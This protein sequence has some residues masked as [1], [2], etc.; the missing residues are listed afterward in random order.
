MPLRSFRDYG[1]GN[2]PLREVPH[3]CP[4]GRL[5]IKL[6]MVNPH[7]SIKDRTAFYL[8]RDIQ[9][10]GQLRSDVTI[11]ESSSGNL[12]MALG[13]LARDA[14]VRFVCLMDHS[15]PPE[16][17]AELSDAGIEV[18]I[19]GRGRYPDCRT[20]RMRRAEE[21]GNHEGWLW[22]NQYANSANVLA[23]YE[24]TGREI[25]EQTDGAVAFV[26][27][28]AGTAGTICGIGQC[29]K[30]RNKHVTVVAVE[31]LGS[32]LFGG[33]EG[34]YL[35][36][37]AGLRGPSRILHRHGHVIDYFCKM[38][39][40]TA[41]AECLRLQQAE[42]LDVGITTGSV[43]RVGSM[44]ASEHPEDI[45]VVVSPDGGE[46]YAHLIHDVSP[47]PEVRETVRLTPFHWEGLDG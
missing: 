14:G 47:S 46:K 32:T 21:L 34:D 26:V 1:L 44:I 40:A 16:K 41:I 33:C 18:E 30:E 7:G 5:F 6:E 27:C 22:T 4:N 2:S 42:G 31:P 39:D 11:V 25:W 3:Y 38:D 43:L 23:H 9:R 13:H 35:S 17:H 10:R 28:S 20:A 29:L 36:V 24:T 19:V 15:I 12:G 8:L 37:G 45:V